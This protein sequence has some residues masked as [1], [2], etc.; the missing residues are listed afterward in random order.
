MINLLVSDLK[1][2]VSYKQ[3]N[4]KED[5]TDADDTELGDIEIWKRWISFAAGV[6]GRGCRLWD[7]FAWWEIKDGLETISHDEPT[8]FDPATVFECKVWVATEWLIRFG[9]IMFQ[10]LNSTKELDARDFESIKP[11]PLCQNIPRH[12]VQRWNFWLS[13]LMELA[14]KRSTTRLKDGVSIEVVLSASCLSR[15]DQ[16]I[17]AMHK[18][19][20]EC[21]AE[22]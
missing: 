6:A 14:D 15:I 21:E 7:G 10:E 5:P 13:R 22:D 19:R 4:I 17:T 11:G 16:A 1:L 20:S 3:S 2:F 12:S 8:S 18:W 9:G